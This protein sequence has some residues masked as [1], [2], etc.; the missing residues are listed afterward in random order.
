MLLISTV[1]AMTMAGPR[2]IQ[3]I[4]EDYPAI[5]IL[6]VRTTAEYLPPQSG[7]SLPL[8]CCLSSLRPLSP[9][10]FFRVYPRAQQFRYH[11]RHFRTALSTARSGA[12]LP[13]VSLP[14]PPLLYLLLTGWILGFTLISR[15]VEGL[16]SLGF[17]GSGL[18]FYWLAAK[19]LSSR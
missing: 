10:W 16:F 6:A 14:L 5:G 13:N 11:R 1:S 18:I 12:A 15:P 8:R 7:Y 3:V 17:I 9:C 4:G 19:R 2:V